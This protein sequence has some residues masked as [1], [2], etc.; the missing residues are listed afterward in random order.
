MLPQSDPARTDTSVDFGAR[1][2]RLWLDVALSVAQMPLSRFATD[3]LAR[4]RRTVQRWRAG[5]SPIPRAVRMRLREYLA[6]RMP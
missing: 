1:H 2:A 4:D 5:T 3:V 6:E